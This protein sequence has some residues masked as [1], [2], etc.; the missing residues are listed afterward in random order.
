MLRLD[1]VSVRYPNAEE[2]AVHD[3]SLE[4][5]PGAHTAILGPNGAGKSTLLRVLAGLQP[6]DRGTASLAGR[7]IGD[8]SRRDLARRMALV[9]SAEEAGFPVRVADYV[10][11]GRNPYLGAL[12]APGPEDRR[13]VDSALERTDL[14]ALGRRYVTQLSAGELQRARVARALAQQP[15]V[16]L[17]DEPTAHLDLGH[18]FAVFELLS[19]LIDEL[20]LTIISVTHNINMASRFC[21]RLV[22][23]RGGSVVADG[24]PAAVL[25]PAHLGAAYAWPVEV[26]STGGLGSVALPVPT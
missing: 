19:Q 12:D 24:A 14:S 5:A 15:E 8:W 25:T 13:V 4:F 2:M 26:I 7:E 23:L 16:L 17:L 6:C 1:G 21:S 18:E 22:L 20:S 11:L 3:V 9:S 10:A